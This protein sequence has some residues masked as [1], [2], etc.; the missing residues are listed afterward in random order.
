MM[1]VPLSNI[2]EEANQQFL[3]ENLEVEDIC[4]IVEDFF[5][6][7]SGS[8]DTYSLTKDTDFWHILT[9]IFYIIYLLPIPCAKKLLWWTFFKK[10]L[11]VLRRF[12]VLYASFSTVD[13]PSLCFSHEFCYRIEAST[14]G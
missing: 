13:A 4:Y 14:S 6:Y 1:D 8:S 9:Q 11:L 10:K 5:N 7:W 12:W 2:D 3:V